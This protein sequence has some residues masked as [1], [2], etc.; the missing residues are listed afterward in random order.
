MN[1]SLLIAALA[2]TFVSAAQAEVT[3]IVG[4][5]VHT[6]GRA[7]TLTTATVIIEDSKVRAVGTDLAVPAGA[8][9]V[10]AKGKVVTPGFFDAFGRLG[11]LEVEQEDSSVDVATTDPRYGAAFAV[12]DAIN[13]R[14]PKLAITRIEGV[15]R[16]LVAPDTAAGD[17]GLRSVIA[18]RA[19][20]IHLGDSGAV[21]TSDGA[22]LVVRM[23]EGG[24]AL[25]GG[26]RGAA[27]LQLRETFEDARDYA[28]NRSDWAQ[29]ARREYAVSRLD[30]DALQPALRGSMPVLVH[31]DRASD[32]RALLK[33]A[34]EFRLKL[35]IVGGAEAWMVAPEL[36]RANVTVILDVMQNLPARFEALGATLENAARLHAA[37]VKLA[38]ATDDVANPRNIKQLAGNAVAYGL[39]FDA[40]LAALTVNPARLYGISSYGTL[41][42][43]MDADVVIW[44]GD[45]LEVT[46]YA[47]AVWIR[48]QAIP[49][50]S[51]QT[52]LKD[53]YFDLGQPLPPAYRK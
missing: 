36:A 44:D 6:G 20:T 27:L 7:G 11:I 10:D 5:K 49:M 28:A 9:V 32:I 39:P 45:P 18:G 41:E 2:A 53:R 42:A 25:V 8:R 13:P 35:A 37:G 29:G 3:A 14:S 50:V 26:A 47:D 24:K 15:T 23:G 40:A 22:A 46:T 43:G 1:R 12:A 17:G 21:L 19:A 16:A 38:F 52:R 31:V 48:G 51:R 34:A 33:F 4:A 30:L